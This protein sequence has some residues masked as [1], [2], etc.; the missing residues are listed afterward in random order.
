MKRILVIE[1]DPVGREVVR[2]CLMR[3]DEPAEPMFAREAAE[4]LEILAAESPDLV[5]I[6]LRMR[7]GDGLEL[8]RRIHRGHPLVPVVLMTRPGS[9]QLAVDALRA[10]AASYVPRDALREELCDTLERVLTLAEARRHRTEVLGYL[11]ARETRFELPNDVSLIGPLLAYVEEGLES[12]GFGDEGVRAQAGMAL[13][14]GIANAMLRGNLEVGSELRAVDREAYDALVQER[15]TQEPYA[16]RR[17]TVTVLESAG[18]LEIRIH[19]QGSGFDP[20][21]VADPV[22]TENLLAVSGR[23]VMLMRTFMDSVRF[24]ERGNEV[25]MV[26]EARD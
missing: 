11:R 20:D 25:V 21:S 6:D 4:A 19:D 26:K 9:E 15:L 12:A 8:V 7:D 2:R 22:A 24:N 3:L 18:R 23:G 5:L 17:V 14:E 1:D 10:G 13:M 16:S